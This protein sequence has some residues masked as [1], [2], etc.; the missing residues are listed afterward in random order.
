MFNNST[1]WIIFILITMTCIAFGLI[2]SSMFDLYKAYQLSSVIP[3]LDKCND[4]KC[5]E[6]VFLDND[7]EH[8]WKDIVQRINSSY[9]Q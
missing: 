6:K 5:T 7:L 4:I 9:N 1:E 2:V 8:E 3:E